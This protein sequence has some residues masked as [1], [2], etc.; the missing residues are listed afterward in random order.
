M[1]LSKIK[2]SEYFYFTSFAGLREILLF[3]FR[4]PLPSALLPMH[5]RMLSLPLPLGGG[6]LSQGSI[7]FLAV[8]GAL[9]I[10]LL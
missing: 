5:I 4:L 1:T 2:L 9:E 10:Y 3:G 6:I 7:F 8:H